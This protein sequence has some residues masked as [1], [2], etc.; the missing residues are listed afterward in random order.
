MVIPTTSK[1]SSG[2][3]GTTEEGAAEEANKKGLKHTFTSYARPSAFHPLVVRCKH[4]RSICNVVCAKGN[5]SKYWPFPLFRNFCSKGGFILER[6]LSLYQM[7]V[8][9]MFVINDR[10][11]Y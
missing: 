3:P 10:F 11:Q 8:I 2:G 4:A 1:L 6:R 5:T 7:H 9:P